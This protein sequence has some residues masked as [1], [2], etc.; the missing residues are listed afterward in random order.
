MSPLDWLLLAILGVSA[1]TGLLR[2]FVG[3][4]A[5]FLAWLLGGTAAF[6][7]GGGV[8]R[9]LADRPDPTPVQLLIGYGACF[10]GVAIV[11]A[12]LSMLARRALAAAG[13]GGID[14][15]LG[16]ALG[17]V[18]G[19]VMACAIVLLL[20]FTP[21]PRQR[22]WQASALVPVFKP[23][24]VWLSTWLPV[25]ARERLDLDGRMPAR[26][27]PELPPLPGLPA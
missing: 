11:V 23:G 19:A 17:S 4:V 15:A 13:L 14:R 6:E 22:Q 5:S 9:M 7:L 12:L 21:M 8:A 3:V 26:T 27:F 1:L 20:G 24:A 10:L 2:G 25:W 18:R 16:L